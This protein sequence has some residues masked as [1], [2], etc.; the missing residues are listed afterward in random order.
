MWSIEAERDVDA[1]PSAIWDRYVD[2]ATWP[3]WAHNT[4]RAAFDGPLALGMTGRVQPD[5]GPAQAV[6]V[7]SF[8]PGRIL[9]TEVRPPGAR[10]TFSY[11]I[12]PTPG[13]GRVR[14]RIEMHGPLAQVYGLMIKSRNARELREELERLATLVGAR[15]GGSSGR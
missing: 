15:A 5:R 14:H 2:P 10:M 11:A 12:A 8:E 1:P 6:V 7:T 13:G 3:T 4:K 9:E